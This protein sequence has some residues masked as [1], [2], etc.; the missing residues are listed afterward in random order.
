VRFASYEK[1]RYVLAILDSATLEKTPTVKMLQIGCSGVLPCRF[2]PRI[3]RRAVLAIL[4]GELWA[5]R[6]VV[7]ELLS[8]L[9]R[10]ASLKAENGLTPREFRILELILQGYSNPA[11][12][13]ELFISLETVRWHRRRLNRKLRGRDQQ[14]PAKATP[15]NLHPLKIA[16]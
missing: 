7:S 4:K 1:D 5:P 8:N 16:N 14:P 9:L 15:P 11:I 3:F 13:R 10:A 12:A 6:C 2:T